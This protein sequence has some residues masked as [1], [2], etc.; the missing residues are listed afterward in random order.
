MNE[1]GP[2][3]TC[4]VDLYWLPLGA[5]DAPAVVRW[6]GR[7]FEAI[8]A[9][10][11]RRER[12][13]L[14]HTALEV[15][16]DGVRFTIEMGP[17]WEGRAHGRD[18]VCQGPVGSR[19]LGRLRLFRYQVRRWRDGTIPDVDE[20]VDS[21]VRL[22]SDRPRARALL[23][24]VDAFPNSTWG[25]DEQG[26]GEMW[27]SNSLTSWL[28]AGSGH[29]L[30]NLRP[31]EGGP[32][33]IRVETVKSGRTAATARATLW[34]NDKPCL[35]TLT[36]AGE[37]ANEPPEFEGLKMPSLPPPEECEGRANAPFP[38]AILDHVDVRIDPATSPAQPNGNP[39]I[40]GWL[41][42][43]DGADHDAMAL[44]LA[45]DVMPPTI[46]HLKKYGWAPTVELTFLLRGLPASGWLAF[47]A[48]ATNLAD[49][50]FDENA[51][52]WDS[53][54]RLVAQSRQLA[55]VGRSK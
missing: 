31:P 50:W 41:A 15:R 48:D 2:E 47:Q 21:P 46:F 45:V 52:I 38:V 7:I 14:Y 49:G 25:R 42:F 37:L 9:G 6:S 20:A 28:L 32:A 55:L 16:L 36:T 35:D 17:V 18:V 24:L 54:G 11:A 26:T 22:S 1:V 34:Q 43:H 39:V 27:N 10:A 5:G 44:P 40:R 19:L 3:S 8:V 30:T 23:D 29:D 33:E 4:G 13:D 53:T 12:C 51:T